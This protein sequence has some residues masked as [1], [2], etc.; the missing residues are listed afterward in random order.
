MWVFTSLLTWRHLVLPRIHRFPLQSSY[1]SLE[2]HTSTLREFK[3]MNEWIHLKGRHELLALQALR[4]FYDLNISLWTV[5]TQALVFVRISCYLWNCTCSLERASLLSCFLL[6]HE[7][8]WCHQHHKGEEGRHQQ[9]CK[10]KRLQGKK[11]SY[12]NQMCFH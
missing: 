11:Y 5:V 8:F 6:H 9:L 7:G 2:V 4:T 3:G 12:Q 10:R 1:S